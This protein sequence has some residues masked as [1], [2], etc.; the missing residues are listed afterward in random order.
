M[1]R[2][3]ISAYACEPHRG[4]EPGVGWN[5]I[6]ELSKRN[7]CHV[8]TR[9]NNRESIEAWFNSNEHS[10]ITFHYYD[11][12]WCFRYIKK[13]FKLTLFYYIFWQ[14]CVLPKYLRLSYRHSFDCTLHL[15]FGSIWLPTTLPFVPIP[16]IVAPIGGGEGVPKSFIRDL[17]LK[18]KIP[19]VLR[20]ALRFIHM[21]S[22]LFLFTTIRAKIIFVRT[23]QTKRFFPPV[24]HKKC[25]CLLET[26]MPKYIFDFEKKWLENTKA[27]NKLKIIT[28]GRLIP[29]KNVMVLLESINQISIP[30]SL[31]VIGSGSESRNI[32]N[33][34]K[35]NNLLE[36]V[37][38]VDELN[39]VEV[40]R[41]LELSE[42]FVF[43]SLRE[44]GSWAL[45]EAMA[46]GL[47]SICL[48]W[49]GMG[50]ITTDSTSVY[51]GGNSNTELR[52]E[53]KEKIEYLYKNYDRLEYLGTNARKRIR[54]NFTWENLIQEFEQVV[55]RTLSN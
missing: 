13:K 36:H 52:E 21:V 26:A 39:H 28:T 12:C 8:V 7:Y 20:Y 55:N 49:T 9:S 42:L 15:T 23:E 51:L 32:K 41:L 25:Y 53:L 16:F 33:F 34:L 43:P 45:M 4:S 31:T 14:L 5:W 22:P 10:N 40:L 27:S 48:N 3:L 35:K 24:F 11:L 30:Y 2:L 19:Q 1:R 54:N 38:L 46:V 44:G 50:V 6:L 18:S 47:P 29:F 17:P 37:T